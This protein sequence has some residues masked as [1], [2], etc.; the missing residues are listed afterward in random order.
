MGRGRRTKPPAWAHVEGGNGHFVQLYDSMLE[1]PAW[2]DL[3]PQAQALYLYC[4]RNSHG[5]ATRDDAKRT[6]GRGDVRLFYMSHNDAVAFG[7]Y[8]ATDFRGLPRD[9]DALISHG[10]IDMIWSGQA[11]RARNIYRLS[12]RWRS[13]GTPAFEMPL[14]YMSS[15]MKKA[16]EEVSEHVA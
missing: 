15:R 4:V 10:F 9:L 12:G 14:K 6:G 11:S 16:V 7:L 13:W 5:Q 8:S 3:A 1:H 2:K